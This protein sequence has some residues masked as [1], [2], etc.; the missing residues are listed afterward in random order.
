MDYNIS[1]MMDP[2][3]RCDGLSSHNAAVLCHGGGFEYWPRSLL[4]GVCRCSQYVFFIFLPQ[5]KDICAWLLGDPAFP[6]GLSVSVIIQLIHP[7]RL[8]Q[9]HPR[10]RCR[11]KSEL[12][13]AIWNVVT[14]SHSLKTAVFALDVLWKTPSNACATVTCGTTG[15]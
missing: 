12:Y 5:S 6:T 3:H 7:A 4:C 10:T 8:P 9:T 13:M 1:E 11:G 2:T 15:F 14:P